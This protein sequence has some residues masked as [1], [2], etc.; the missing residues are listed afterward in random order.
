MNRTCTLDYAGTLKQIPIP[1]P[2]SRLSENLCAGD[3]G[4]KIFKALRWFL[5][6]QDCG[7]LDVHSI[8]S[9]KSKLQN[10]KHIITH[11]NNYSKYKFRFVRAEIKVWKHTTDYYMEGT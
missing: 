9:E 2:N 5:P 8:L 6:R 10:N 1:E 4:I 7:P 3:L 11:S